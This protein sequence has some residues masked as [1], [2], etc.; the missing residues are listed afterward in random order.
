[1]E[2]VTTSSDPVTHAATSCAEI[3]PLIP[4][5][6]AFA[7]VPRPADHPGVHDAAPLLPLIYSSSR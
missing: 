5:L 1:M 3:L 4:V 7:F 2:C 6:I